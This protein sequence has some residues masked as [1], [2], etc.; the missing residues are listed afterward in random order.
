[1]AGACKG[2]PKKR[3]ISQ[4]RDIREVHRDGRHPYLVEEINWMR[5]VHISNTKPLRGR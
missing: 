3:L 2:I 1:M 5:R 4:M